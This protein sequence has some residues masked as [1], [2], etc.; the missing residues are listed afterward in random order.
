LIGMALWMRSLD[1]AVP[2]AWAGVAL[3]TLACLSCAL[4]TRPGH[5]AL[6]LVLPLFVTTPV[7]TAPF[8]ARSTTAM[9]A[10]VLGY[11]AGCV[12]LWHSH[13]GSTVWLA[14][15][16]QAIAGAVVGM[17][18]HSIVDH[19]R[20]GH[21][22]AEQELEQRAHLDSLTAVLNRRHFIEM[23]ELLLGRLHAGQQLS[24]CFIDLD[25]FK[26]VND[27]GSHR[28]GDQMLVA[29][30]QRLLAV[31]SGQRLVGRLGGEEFALLLPDMAID[32][33][34]LLAEQL[35]DEIAMTCVDGFSVTAS[36]GVAEWKHGE[37][38]SDLLH[39]ADLALLA[40][41]RNGRNRIVHWSPE[42]AAAT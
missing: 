12:A 20:R 27:D 35:C 31:S 41:K 15:G 23:G 9:L 17:L 22:L 19:A 30:A 2:F 3:Q 40:A 28:I 36:V 6:A 11:L 14:F 8:W 5:G 4:M 42:L 16:V 24:A 13:T 21:F 39:R 32:A 1:S 38:L 26:R 29:I 37:S 18:V 25:H 10:I 7:V 34:Q 33:A